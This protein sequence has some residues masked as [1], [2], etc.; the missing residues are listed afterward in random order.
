MIASLV[1]D[2]MN[3]VIPTTVVDNF[4]EDPIAIRKYA[5]SLDYELDPEGRWPG[6]RSKNLHIINRGL[7]DNIC[8]KFFSLFYDVENDENL[9]WTV[10][11]AFQLTDSSYE[12][13]W[14][15]SDLSLISAVIYL[16]DNPDPNTG[17]TI[18]KPKTVGTKMLHT[19]E[20]IRQIRNKNNGNYRKENNEQFEESIIIKNKFNRLVA[21]DGYSYHGANM[22]EGSTEETSRLTL[23]F[24]VEELRGNKYPIQK[25]RTIVYE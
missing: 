24:F 25:L 18:Y 23:V 9:R 8:E 10:K 11:A 21:F 6:K 16:N 20:K 1:K 3:Y 14:V 17:T 13:G 22:F 2:K 5:L 15:H 4:F 19:E 7:F 12:E